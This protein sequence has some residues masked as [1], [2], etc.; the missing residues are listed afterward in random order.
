MII[1]PLR[2]YIVA[3]LH[4]ADIVPDAGM[5][6]ALSLIVPMIEG[7]I[8]RLIDLEAQTAVTW[9]SVIPGAIASVARRV[10]AGDHREAC[11]AGNSRPEGSLADG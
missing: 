7:D 9:H 5:I 4:R 10:E 11:R 8:V 3:L 2:A 6:A 1:D